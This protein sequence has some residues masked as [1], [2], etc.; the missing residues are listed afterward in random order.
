MILP[1]LENPHVRVDNENYSHLRSWSA[2]GWLVWTYFDIVSHWQLKKLFHHVMSCFDGN[3]PILTTPDRNHRNH[4]PSSTQEIKRFYSATAEKQQPPSPTT[5]PSYQPKRRC[6]NRRSRCKRKQNMKKWTT[7]SKSESLFNQFK[8]LS[9]RPGA[10][11]YT[12]KVAHP[13]FN[14][15]QF[16]RGQPPACQCWG[17]TPSS[18]GISRWCSLQVGLSSMIS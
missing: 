18:P 16:W 10:Q 7:W 9:T 13:F 2:F 1:T 11:V 12:W 8:L 17:G 4:G 14:I 3:V 6:F 15:E 5:G